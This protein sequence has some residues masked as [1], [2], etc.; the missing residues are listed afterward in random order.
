MHNQ[1]LNELTKRNRQLLD[2]W[3]RTDIE[4]NRVSEDLHLTTGRLEQLRNE[5]ANLR[6][7]KKIWEVSKHKETSRLMLIFF[8]ERSRALGGGEQNIDYGEISSFRSHEQRTEN[9]Q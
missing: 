8:V 6:A 1:E 9:A 5:N 4:C 7:E 2:Q 3:T